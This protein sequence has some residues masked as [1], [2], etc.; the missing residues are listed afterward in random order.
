[1]AT[2]VTTELAPK[3][4]YLA[5]QRL[6]A[7]LA[8]L[9]FVKRLES[10]ARERRLVEVARAV[11][12]QPKVVLLDEPAAGL[13]DEET[14]HLAAVIRAGDGMLPLHLALEAQSV[15]EAVSE[16]EHEASQVC[17][18]AAAVLAEAVVVDFQS[19]SLFRD[20]FLFSCSLPSSRKKP[21]LSTGFD[22]TDPY[23]FMENDFVSG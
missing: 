16:E 11:V 8:G 12:G 20:H 14:K 9:S 4:A 19:Y 18:G 7:A 2:T 23:G 3:P 15:I 6:S 21:V 17:L 10:D 22:E 5:M 1:M 13:S